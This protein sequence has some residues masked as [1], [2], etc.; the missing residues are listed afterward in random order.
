MF[1]LNKHLAT[2]EKVVH[3]FRPA[4]RAYIFHY[5]FYILLCAVS[6][7]AQAYL[8][9]RGLGIQDINDNIRYSYFL[10][11]LLSAIIFFSLIMLVRIEWRIISRRYAL[12]NHRLLYSRGIFFETL[13]TI[14]YQY[15]T[16]IG[17]QQSLWDKILNT[18]SLVIDTASTEADIRY[19]KIAR[20]LHVKKLINDNQMHALGQS[21]KIHGSA[22]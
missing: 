4:R 5:L 10:L 12:T 3:F 9:I 7:L 8:I 6:F 16:D 1:T 20:P 15:I 2:D 17:F 22:T 13:K 18:G 21:R 19:R 11:F 14:N